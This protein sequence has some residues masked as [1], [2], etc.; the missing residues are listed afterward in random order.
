LNFEEREK[1]LRIIFAKINSGKKASL[2]QMTKH[3]MDVVNENEQTNKKNDPLD[4]TNERNSLKESILERSRALGIR[5]KTDDS[6]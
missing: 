4:L 2:N 1:I 6:I 5:E 3:Y